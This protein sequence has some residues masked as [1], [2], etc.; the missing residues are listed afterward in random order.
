MGNGSKSLALILVVIFLTSLVA[1]QL[2]TVKAQSKTIIV[3]YD[4]PTIS[5]AIGNATAG[6]II[7]VKNANYSEQTLE[8]DKPLKIISAIPY[9][10]Q[11]SLHPSTHPV[12]YSGTI[13]QEY[14]DCISIRADNVELSGFQIL[15]DGGDISAVG[16]QIQII[17]NT[18][19]TQR[20]SMGLQL[21]GDLSQVI[22]NSMSSLSINGNNQTATDNNIGVISE[23][24][25]GAI[26]VTGSY[27]TVA[28]NKGG[29][30]SLVGSYNTIDQNLF[31]GSGGIGINLH[32]ANHNIISRNTE[33]GAPEGIIVNSDF[34]ATCD[35]NSFSGNLVEEAALW[36]V[37][38]GRGS[39]NVFYR[40]IIANTYGIKNTTDTSIDGY[41]LALGGTH[42]TTTDNVFYDNVFMNNLKNFGAN[43]QVVGSNYFDNG[44]LGNYWDDYLLKYP[45]ATE[46][47]N[48]GI[49][50]TPYLVYGNCFD[51]YP[52]LNPPDISQLTPTL[53]NPW[54]PTL[55]IGTWPP[56]LPVIVPSYS[57]NVNPTATPSISQTPTATPTVPELSWLTIIPLLIAMLVVATVVRHKKPLNSSN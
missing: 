19:G 38:V 6:D 10:V 2:S 20:T 44:S 29:W 32:N 40:N 4:Y 52:I 48:S 55:P 12:D 41:A 11:I 45:T 33:I 34:N 26:S 47:H 9:Q 54:A 46:V 22:G 17:N 7:I 39:N 42:L 36:A 31:N 8:I 35:Y 49:G 23:Y 5:S 3:P 28:R 30:I 14:N 13:L 18:L 57:P 25:V 27:N 21:T 56:A 43:W 16:N 24:K 53:P 1:L 37:L 50:N 51:N 15:S